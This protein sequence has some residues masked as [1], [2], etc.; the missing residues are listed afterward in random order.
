MYQVLWHAWE[1]AALRLAI[2]VD[3]TEA[4]L[5]RIARLACRKELHDRHVRDE[6]NKSDLTSYQLVLPLK[7]DS[8]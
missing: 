1:R 7:D 8:L 4:G 5:Q 2:V 6:M 3:H